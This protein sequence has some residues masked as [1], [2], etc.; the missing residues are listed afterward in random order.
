MTEPTFD[1]NEAFV[2]GPVWYNEAAP[3]SEDVWNKLGQTKLE[4][5]LEAAVSTSF[6]FITSFVIWQGIAQP[7]F[8]YHVTLA[9]NFWL[10]TIF[11]LASLIRQY[12]FRRFFNAGI[13]RTIHKFVAKLWS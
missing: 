1:E 6:G 11:T 5:F 9:A 4:S 8:H 13:H 7:L 2:L 12:V 10:T 3:V